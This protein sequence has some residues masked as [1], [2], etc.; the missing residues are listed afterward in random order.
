MLRDEAAD[1]LW[2]A[3]KDYIPDARKRAVPDSLVDYDRDVICV[4]VGSKQQAIFII[5]C[6]VILLRHV[7]VLTPRG[8]PTYRACRHAHYFVRSILDP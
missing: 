8:G 2:T 7:P 1:L 3:I 5:P 4:F 6:T